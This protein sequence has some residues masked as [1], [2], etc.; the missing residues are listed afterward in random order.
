MSTTAGAANQVGLISKMFLPG[1]IGLGAVVALAGIGLLAGATLTAMGIRLV[2]FGALLIAIGIGVALSARADAC[3]ACR[4]AL[5]STSTAWPIDHEAMIV[6]STQMAGASGPESLLALFDA[7][8]PATTAPVKAA[9]LVSYCPKCEAVARVQTCKQ[10]LLAD[11]ATTE[12]DMSPAVDLQGH[13]V[14]RLIEAVGARNTRWANV[15]Y[16]R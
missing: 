14:K 12:H 13:G 6:L 5:Q 8:F 9:L 11:G 7:P 2:L 15:A 3:S 10:K 4:A 1:R 16:G